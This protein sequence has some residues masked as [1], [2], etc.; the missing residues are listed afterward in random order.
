M[1]K[2]VR[3]AFL[4]S[5][6]SCAPVTHVA[7]QGS[8]CLTQADSVQVYLDMLQRYYTN[9]DSAQTVAAGGPWASPGAIKLV[10]KRATCS[11][12]VSAFNAASESTSG[13]PLDTSAYIFAVGGSGFA[14]FRPG[15]IVDGKRTFYLFS[16]NWVLKGAIVG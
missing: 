4:F 14:Y 8:A 5:V 3:L 2:L 10:T 7:A 9:A 11:A 16:L 12:G 15:D 6:A 1:T 13:A